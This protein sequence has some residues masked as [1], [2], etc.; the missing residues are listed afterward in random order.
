MNR[1][2]NGACT[3]WGAST[4]AED[5][6]QDVFADA[7]VG[8]PRFRG[9]SQLHTWLFGIAKFKVHKFLQERRRRGH[10]LV[11]VHDDD[12]RTDEIPQE[13]ESPEDEIARRE[14]LTVT[15]RSMIESLP[16]KYCLPL[17]LLT[18]GLTRRQIAAELDWPVGTVKS[19][20]SRG[21]GR[22]K[23]EVP[24]DLKN[25]PLW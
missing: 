19:R 6:M 22:L 2:T 15:L 13:R 14:L 12:A 3:H 4:R 24:D 5:V 16:E 21:I 8:L 1:S 7:Y 11:L 18:R 9:D 17:K 10:V 20:I 23:N 25:E